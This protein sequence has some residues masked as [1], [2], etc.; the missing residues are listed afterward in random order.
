MPIT[1]DDFKINNQS[2]EGI[3][4]KFED[5]CRLLFTNEFLSNNKS[6]KYLHANPNNPGLEAEPILDETNNV[7]IGFQ[8]KY[9]ESKVSYDQINN[10][11]EKIVK[12]YNG[13]VGLVYLF[14]NKPL[15]SKSLES[16]RNILQAANIQLELITDNVILD[17]VISKYPYLS[18]YFFGKFNL[19]LNWFKEHDK[20]IFQIM[21]DRYTADFNVETE[22]LDELSLFVRDQRAVDYINA[23]KTSLIKQIDEIYD[24]YRFTSKQD[25][26]IYEYLNTLKKA[27]SEL[28]I[29]NTETLDSAINWFDQI[30]GIINN[31]KNEYKEKNVQSHDNSKGNN[32]NSNDEQNNEIQNLEEKINTLLLEYVKFASHEK[33]LLQSKVLKISGKAGTGKTQLL[34]FKTKELLDNSVPVLLLDASIFLKDDTIEKQ[35]MDS[36]SFGNSFDDLIEALETIGE[37]QNRIIPIFIDALNETWNKRLWKTGLPSIIGKIKK[38][39]MIR[40]VIS[41]R[42][43]YETT[44]F[45]ESMQNDEDVVAI[46]HRGFAMNGLKAIEEFL[47]HYNIPFTPLDYLGGELSNPLFLSFYCK[48]YNGKNISLPELYE[49][50]INRANNNI[51]RGN[52]IFTD[53][54]FTD[55]DIILKPFIQELSEYFIRHNK[56]YITRK[57]LLDLKFW[58]MYELSPGLIINYLLREGILSESKSNGNDILRFSFDQMNDYYCAKVIFGMFESKEKIKKYLSDNVLGIHDGKLGDFEN[59]DLFIAV[60]ALYAKKYGEECIDIIDNIEEDDDK[61]KVFNGYI[62]SFHWRD[63]TFISAKSFTDMIKKYQCNL[64]IVWPVLIGNS[65]KISHPLNADFLHRF[66]KGYKLNQRD[67]FWTVYINQLKNEEGN[68]IIQLIELYNQGS[69]LKVQDNKQNELILTL[70]GWLLTS[71]NR[72]LRDN[73]SKAMIEILKNHF[74]LCL[75]ILKKFDDIDDPYVIQRLY[76]IV[77]GACC[78]KNSEGSYQELAEYVYRNIFDKEMV[79]PD[80]LLRDYARLIIE[81]FLYDNPAYEGKIDPNKITPPYKSENIQKIENQHYLD[82]EYDGGILCLLHSMRFSFGD[83]GM[84]GDFGRYVFQS[85]LNNFDIDEKEVFNYAVYF[86]INELGYTNKLFEEIDKQYQYHNYD[87]HN[88]I[89]TERIGKKYQ[90]IAMYNILARVS[91][92]CKMI[93]RWSSPKK[94]I[95]FKGPWDLFI[96]DFDPT[97]SKSFP[98]C[99]DAPYF[100]ELS[101]FIKKSR[102]DNLNSNVSNIESTKHWLNNSGYF[103]RNLKNSLILTDE[104][105]VKWV[106]LTRY[107]DT[108]R[109]NLN[110][111]KLL[112]W[113]WQYAYFVTEEQ[114]KEFQEN[115]QSKRSIFTNDTSSH[116]ETY[117]IFNREYSWAPSYQDFKQHAWVNAQLKT[118]KYKTEIIQIPDFSSFEHAE[119]LPANLDADNVEDFS[120]SLKFKDEKRQ[121]EIMKPIGKILHAT[122]DIIWEAEYDGSKEDTISYS[123]PCYKI[124]KVMNLKQLESDGFFY[125]ADGELAAFDTD[126][127]QKVNNVVIRKDILDEFLDK[128][129]MKLI[130]L[131]KGS[132][133]I[134]HEKNYSVTRWS[135]WEGLFRYEGNTIDGKMKMMNINNGDS[136]D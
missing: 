53:K 117:S 68:R 116:H 130:W 40:L 36:I 100:Y 107:C 44:V 32:L 132:R 51:Y 26:Y 115:F 55:N 87:R 25:K 131:V 33:K 42:S 39:K 72:W 126:L 62:S 118:G 12:Y 111:E 124:I 122:T 13:K 134:Y 27:I 38:N 104:N 129:K 106:C 16:T 30:N 73:V 24:Y 58:D 67:F 10:S 5:L 43:E 94:E 99:K 9:F 135:D 78:K 31:F 19:D 50:V 57:E 52:R 102:E 7:M 59:V 74:E 8:A 80:I 91:D 69:E 37:I 75:I 101:E 82:R 133:E 46:H 21:G 49:R 85:A 97:L 60:C 23:K 22:Y 56:K 71:S 108:G 83:K 35:I 4:L 96:R 109:K 105:D 77:F 81:L 1:W 66:L 41:Y 70:F 86:I 47:N 88:N 125:T 119:H 6:H 65:T 120:K 64:D 123:A 14:C 20:S 95:Q 89:K 17:L 114:A 79:Y 127:T 121:E 18:T 113:S 61:K 29:V 54:G 28:K 103:F 84:Y 11:A 45:P 2:S 3:Q 110:F 98:L 90:W 128:N 112:I 136:H 63:G 15:T 76:G 93:N 92:H 34:A 48:T